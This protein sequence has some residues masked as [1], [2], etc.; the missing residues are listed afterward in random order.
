M[1]NGKIPN[2]NTI[3]PIAGYEKEIKRLME[4]M[5]LTTEDICMVSVP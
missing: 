2:P 1:K 3:H 5:T 4:P